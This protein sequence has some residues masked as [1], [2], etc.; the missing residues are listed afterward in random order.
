M[1]FSTGEVWADGL[2]NAVALGFDYRGRLW[3]VDNGPDNLQRPDLGVDIYNDNPGEEVNLLD[4]PVGKKFGYPYC[5]SAGNLTA[6]FSVDP[7]RGTQFAWPGIGYNDTWCRDPDNNQPPLATIPAHSS[8]L[9]VVFFSDRSTGAVSGFGCDSG[10]G[11]FPC[12]YAN[13]AFIALHGSWNSRIPKGY[14]VSH[15]QFSNVAP[16]LPNNGSNGL[17]DI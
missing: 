4:G 12:T 16:F 9:Q 5:F 3:E 13:D 7:I 1:D 11:A 17:E 6:P 2:R 14:R 15:L 8:P 10:P